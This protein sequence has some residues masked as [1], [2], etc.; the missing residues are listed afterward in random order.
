MSHR[1]SV[2]KTIDFPAIGCSVG[3]VEVTPLGDNKYRL[4]EAVPLSECT[5]IYDVIKAKRIDDT[6]IQF[7]RVAEPSN[8]KT[9]S[10]GIPKEHAD[11]AVLEGAF[12]IC[13][14]A[15]AGSVPVLIGVGGGSF[16]V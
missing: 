5:T 1:S 14:P 3:N 6:T 13:G 10:Y 9:Y 7:V 12:P 11:A 4:E 2:H 16:V 8:W 15:A